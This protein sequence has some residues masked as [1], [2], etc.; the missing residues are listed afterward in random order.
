MVISSEHLRIY[1]IWLARLFHL[2]NSFPHRTSKTI[3]HIHLQRRR[4]Y[5]L[6]SFYLR[7]DITSAKRAQQT[8]SLCCNLSCLPHLDSS[9]L[10]LQSFLESHSL[11]TA[12][13]SPVGHSNSLLRHL[14]FFS[15][16]WSTHLSSPS[17]TRSLL[18]HCPLS[19]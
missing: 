13:H 19:H 9:V 17:Q 1:H 7:N 15:S 2:H 11:S 6:N 10:S 12:R 4:I 8:A 18:M 14:Q 5:L 3:I 16:D